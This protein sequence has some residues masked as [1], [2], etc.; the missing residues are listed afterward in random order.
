MQITDQIGKALF[1]H[2]PPQ[3]IISLVPSQTELLYTL[4]LDN[5]VVGITKFCVHPAQWH[6]HKKRIGGTKN[7][8]L[9]T[10]RQLQPDL[11]IANKEENNKEQV[12]ALQAVYPVYISDINN[13]EEA[14]VMIKDIGSITNTQAPAAAF[15]ENIKQAFCNLLPLST[16]INT[17]YLIWQDPFMTVGGDTF[18]NHQLAVCGFKNIFSHLQRYPVV[19][20][21]ALQQA[22]CELLLLSSEP[23]PFKEKHIAA[24]QKQLPHTRIALAD[25]EYFSWYGSRLLHAPAYFKELMT[26]LA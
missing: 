20:I 9:E 7:I 11:I 10:I 16:P 23:Y 6:Q 21:E 14:L 2:N 3:R 1:I 4:G 25:G 17:A 15:I 5:N 13:L 24:L 19:T 12:E 26:C 18:I 22:N 8:N